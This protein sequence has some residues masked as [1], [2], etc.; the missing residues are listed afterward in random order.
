MSTDGS[1]A[2]N[3]LA[4]H[5]FAVLTTYRK[6]GAPVPTTVWF[7]YDGGKVYITTRAASGKL[8]RIRNDA[9]VTLS[10]SDR[11]GTLLGESE[12]AGTA[13]EALGDEREQANAAL[14]QKYGETWTRVVG[15][16]GDSPER[17][18]IVVEC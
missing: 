7:A 8:K 6:T 9:R 15:D 3:A 13:R 17:A 18:Y 2:G 4:A 1:Q 16:G 14:A 11:V 12:V 5:E 10:P